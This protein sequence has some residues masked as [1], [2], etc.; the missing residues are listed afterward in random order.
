MKQLNKILDLIYPAKCINC[1]Q[2]ICEYNNLCND[3]FGNIEFVLN[4][5]SCKICG[6]FIEYIVEDKICKKCE[7]EIPIYNKIISPF[8][9]NDFIKELIYNYKYYDQQHLAIFFGKAIANKIKNIADISNIDYI[10]P[11]PLHFI[12]F[13]KRKFNQSGIISEIIGKSLG[14]KV[15]HDMV[16]RIRNT[17][18]QNS[19]NFH[20]RCDNVKHAFALN[21]KYLNIITDKN[22]L[23][24]DDII[25]TGSTIKEAGEVIVASGASRLYV[26]SV[27]RT[28]MQKKL[29]I[30][31]IEFIIQA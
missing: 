2:F 24:I 12:K 5:N 28:R 10:V 23:L 16:I 25:T 27:C 31:E 3:C 26:A 15:I 4:S 8:Y 9:Y 21:S 17:S 20:E 18:A 14:I 19:L 13:F 29:D 11:I 30:S 22:I 6:D 1:N 7:S